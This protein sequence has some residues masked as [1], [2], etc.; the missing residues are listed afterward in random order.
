MEISSSKRKARKDIK[1]NSNRNQFILGEK[2]NDDING[3]NTKEK[4]KQ[5][6]IEGKSEIETLKIV[7]NNKLPKPK[8]WDENKIWS[9]GYH[10]VLLGYLNAYFDHCPIKVSPN[11]IWQLILNLFSKYVNDYSEELRNIFV[12]FEGKKDIECIRIGKFKDVYEYEDDLIDEFCKR[13]SE[14]IGTELT[15]IL[16]PNF[17]T[18]TK[19]S[20]IAGKVSI[21]STFKKYFN[22]RIGMVSCGIPYILLEGNLEDWKKILEKLKSLSKCGFSTKKIEE[23]IIEIINTKEG[24]I[25]LDFWRKI[26]M[27][28]KGTITEEKD[29]MDVEVEREL[30]TGWILD[31][32]NKTQVKKDDLKNLKE[33]VISAPVTV[34]EVETGETRPAVIYAGIRDL[35]QD[36]NTFIVEPIVNYCFSFNEPFCSMP[37]EEEDF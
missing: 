4:L 33:E 34:K 5:N 27:E 15:D 17:T 13:I 22:Y 6:I 19:E 35:K 20:I 9:F 18:S 30:I 32:Y 24:K 21:M 3:I 26:I 12:N 11:I 25:N 28:T 10:K 8:K 29:C 7:L 16:T 37:F 36:P 1:Q 14:N 31:F 23:D 2:K